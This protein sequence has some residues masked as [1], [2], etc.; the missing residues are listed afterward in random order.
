M[1][2]VESRVEAR[3][4]KISVHSKALLDVHIAAIYPT[5]PPQVATSWSISSLS[6]RVT[7]DTHRP[8]K[9]LIC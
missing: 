3:M 4:L 7:N 2:N 1:I 5:L 6:R 9:T 8:E